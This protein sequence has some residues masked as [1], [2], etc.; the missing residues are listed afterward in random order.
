[1]GIPEG[2]AGTGNDA[3]AGG[4]AR[5]LAEG[6]DSRW[7]HRAM[8]DE[9][10][11]TRGLGGHTQQ[12]RGGGNN[13][14]GSTGE[15]SAG[16]LP[17]RSIGAFVR[18]AATRIAAWLVVI[19]ASL[20]FAGPANAQGTLEVASITLTVEDVGGGELGC[21]GTGCGTENERTMWLGGE[22][23]R[24][25]RIELDS[26][27][28]LVSFIGLYGSGFYQRWTLHVGSTSLP[29]A[30]ARYAAGNDAIT[31][32]STGL[33]WSVGDTVQL[34]VTEPLVPTGPKFPHLVKIG[35]EHS[36]LENPEP[37]TA[38]AMRSNAATISTETPSPTASKA[39]TATSSTSTPQP[40]CCRRRR[41]SSTT[42]R[43][44]RGA[45]SGDGPTAGASR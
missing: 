29:F 8:T 40:E 35:Y 18:K 27:T 30:D 34:R 32:D 43:P 9:T 37:N 11:T 26:G 14:W 36:L 1:M 12:N 38:I 2:R 7:L 25:L 6:L 15:G 5:R 42:T 44:S 4:A 39:E 21:A 20:G 13:A 22:G 16:R 19:A 10:K 45:K 17:Q 23:R 28:L 41:V 24:I 3:P 31:W 33:S